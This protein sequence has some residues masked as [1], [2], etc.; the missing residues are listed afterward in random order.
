MGEEY[1]LPIKHFV[2]AVFESLPQSKEFQ[3]NIASI[4]ETKMETSGSRD[5]RCFVSSIGDCW[6]WV[7]IEIRKEQMKNVLLLSLFLVIGCHGP[8]YNPRAT[9][10]ESESLSQ[11]TQL[12]RGFDKA[13]EAYFSRD[14]QW[15]IFQAV[16]RG[17]QQY[18]MYIAAVKHENGEIKG[19]ATPVRVSPQN[20]RNTCGFFSPD[21]N[22][23]IFGST[24]NKDD[25]TEAT[26]GY[27]RQGQS[28]K[29]SYPAGMEIFRA[30]GWQGALSGAEP[31]KTVDLAKH[32][33][34][35]NTAYDAEG[36]FS[37]D[38]KWIVFTS[39]RTGDLDLY[40]MRSDGSD[41]VRLTT[42]PGYDGGPFFSPDGKKV[43]YRSDR[44]SNDLLQIYVSDVVYD[45]TGKIVGLTNEQALTKNAHVNWGPFFHPDGQHI[46][47]AASDD[48]HKNYDLWLMRID[49]SRKTRLTFDTVADVLPVFSPDGKYLLWASRR[50]DDKS[51]QVIIARFKFPPG[52]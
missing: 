38:G 16:P 24:A 5:L 4:A 14:M 6:N 7:M 18:Q 10:T 52:A 19:L 30:D 48:T 9:T 15:L 2:G 37:P 22:S 34:T 11:I 28:Y 45:P 25:P 29:W 43:L 47:Y 41:V 42:T 49:G 26:S 44:E 21:G 31:G 36:S 3:C 8:E 51:V 35:D 1:R 46:I 20:S 33:L 23:V 32:P 12:T 39:N 40:A 17:E 27:Q 13:G 50:S